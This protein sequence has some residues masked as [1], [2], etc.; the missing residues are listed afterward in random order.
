MKDFVDAL[1]NYANFKGRTRRKSFWIFIL[2]SMGIS[3]LLSVIGG[4]IDFNFLST[5][6]GLAILLPSLAIGA[7]RMHDAGKSGWFYLIPFYNLYLAIQPSEPNV[8][9][10]GAPVEK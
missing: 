2:I 4:M 9:T 6:Y 7:R 10:W 5:I 1:K 3:V 8:N